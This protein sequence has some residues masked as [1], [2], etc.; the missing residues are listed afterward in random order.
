M[1]KT[2]KLTVMN[3]KCAPSSLSQA[4]ALASVSDVTNAI[5][6]PPAIFLQSVADILKN[7]NLG[8]QNGFW[9][10]GAYTG[11]YSFNQLKSIGVKYAIIGHSE[12]RLLFKEDSQ[13]ISKKIA[14]ALA[15]GIS[16]IICVGE[17]KRTTISSAIK[18]VIA[19]LDD[20][21]L[22][23][24]HSRGSSCRSCTLSCHSKVSPS[25]PSSSVISR[26]HRESRIHIDPRFSEGDERM[27]E[28]GN[29][30]TS[31]LVSSRHSRE[32]GNPETRIS[33]ERLNKIILAY[34]PIWAIGTGKN[35]TL[36][37]ILPVMSAMT[38]R[39]AEIFGKKIKIVY[40]GSVNPENVNMYIDSSLIDGVLVGGAS[41]DK[42]KS[43]AII[44]KVKNL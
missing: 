26:V 3:W 39:F 18:T 15:T 44:N 8:A 13:I 1:K 23:L 35:A 27:S 10:E 28:S 40:G 14:S 41:A 34:E 25:F 43:M 5:I 30:D 33:K 31:V 32:S 11:E 17:K 36:N 38:N 12:R 6:C 37:E 20:L 29:P 19:E 21:F 16:P 7:A 4:R 9:E 2:N 22:P 24:Y 42:Q